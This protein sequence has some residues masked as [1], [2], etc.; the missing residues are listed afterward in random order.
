MAGVPLTQSLWLHRQQVATWTMYHDWITK[1]PQ[2]HTKCCTRLTQ[3]RSMTKWAI[4]LGC[5]MRQHIIGPSNWKPLAWCQ[6]MYWP[7]WCSN[8]GQSLVKQWSFIGH[9]LVTQLPNNDVAKQLP[10]MSE[11]PTQ[12]VLHTANGD[13][14]ADVSIPRPV[15][16]TGKGSNWQRLAAGGFGVGPTPKPAIMTRCPRPTSTG[17][18]LGKGWTTGGGAPLV[19]QRL[20]TLAKRAPRPCASVGL[21]RPCPP[22]GACGVPQ[23]CPEP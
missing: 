17:G 19:L 2:H 15:G 22:T 18:R 5:S 14:G 21:A 12:A 10:D 3:P 9:S 20:P 1:Q 4:Q 16:G 13:E 7:K 23:L 6:L 11:A 8:G